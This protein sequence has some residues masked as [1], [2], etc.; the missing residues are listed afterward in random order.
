MVPDHHGC[1]RSAKPQDYNYNLEK[2][3]DHLNLDNITLV[4]HDWGGAIGMGYAVR[5]PEKIKRLVIFNT[6]AFI[7]NR[8]PFTINLCRNPVIGPLAI[9]TLN[10]F[11]KMGVA[12][13]CKQRQRMTPQVRKGYLAP[14]N[15]PENRIGNLRFVQDIPMSPEVPSYPVVEEI[16]S[17]LESFRD[18][19]M[20]IVWGMQDFCFN[21]YFLSRW[22]R[23]FPEAE[24]HEVENAG[25]Y[26]VED[27]YENIISWMIGFL[28][29][30]PI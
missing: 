10:L 19:P 11:A 22:K 3:V 28:R 23:Y 9:Q 24:V 4:V 29:E 5:H 14:Y 25:H 27:A 12:W 18:R 2:L 13:A 26:I 1:G 17:R 16:E 7:S 21:D 20:M 6:A 30:H 15:S 8:I